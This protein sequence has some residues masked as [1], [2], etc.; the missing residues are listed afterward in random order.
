MIKILCFGD[1]NTWG[2]QANSGQRFAKPQRWPGIMAQWFAKHAQVI[3][4]GRPGRTTYCSDEQFGFTR[5]ITD[6]LTELDQQQPDWLVLMLGTNDLFPA[7][8]LTAQQ[9]AANLEKMISELKEHCAQRQLIQPKVL[10]LAPPAIN[11]SGSFAQLF[12]GAE[13]QSQLLAT[14]YQDLAVRQDCE[15]LDVAQHITATLQD[16][17]H[18]NEIQHQALAEAL[19]QKLAKADQQLSPHFSHLPCA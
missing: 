12:R 7:F 15:F 4:N 10:I 6:L 17:V 19:A 8:G 11:H 18:M 16:G 1:S 3:E 13:Q 14:Y 9:V 5:G 2:Y